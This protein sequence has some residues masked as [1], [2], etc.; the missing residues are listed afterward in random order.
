MLM[1]SWQVSSL[2]PTRQRKAMSTATIGYTFEAA[3]ALWAMGPLRG[4]W[5]H[6]TGRGV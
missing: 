4:K 6:C 5:F 1:G 3:S 2:T